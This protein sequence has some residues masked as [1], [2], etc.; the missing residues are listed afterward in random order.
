M[1][2]SD[3]YVFERLQIC[4]AETMGLDMDAVKP[5]TRLFGDLMADS[6]DAVELLM[7]LEEEFRFEIE[8]EEY[9]D[10]VFH[11]SPIEKIEA[12]IK[13]KLKEQLPKA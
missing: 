8:D 3:Q 9:D 4:I 1:S 11:D 6:L 5:E 7:R 12:A 13:S 10:V 2:E